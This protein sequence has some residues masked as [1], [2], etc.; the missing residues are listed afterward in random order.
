MLVAAAGISSRK[1]RQ[2]K[3]IG[4]RHPTDVAV[5]GANDL[6]VF[7]L[8]IA[9][10]TTNMSGPVHT[11]VLQGAIRQHSYTYRARRRWAALWHEWTGTSRGRYSHCYSTSQCNLN[12]K[13]RK[14]LPW[15]PAATLRNTRSTSYEPDHYSLCNRYR[16]KPIGRRILRPSNQFDGFARSRRAPARAARCR[17]GA[18]FHRR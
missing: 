8:S 16:C 18:E 13:P 4:V 5:D 3:P 11:S 14:T 10:A 15:R 6:M 1:T 2:S 7:F 17:R 9:H 12:V